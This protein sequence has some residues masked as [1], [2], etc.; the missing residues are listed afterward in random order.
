MIYLK[1]GEG[2]AA[3]G[4]HQMHLAGFIHR[5]IKPQNLLIDHAGHVK[6]LDFGLTMKKEGE[7]GDEF[8]MAMIFAVIQ[9]LVQARFTDF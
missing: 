7:T 9:R 2:Q 6:L 1:R 5:D 4:L 8:S 3:L